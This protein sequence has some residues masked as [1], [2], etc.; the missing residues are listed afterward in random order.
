V[1]NEDLKS[2]ILQNPTIDEMRKNGRKSGYSTLKEAGYKKV[3][4]NLTTIEEVQQAVS[5]EV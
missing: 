3:L 1:I 2:L 4:Q 5:L